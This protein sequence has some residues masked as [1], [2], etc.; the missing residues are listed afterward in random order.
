MAAF[1]LQ[2]HETRQLATPGNWLLCRKIPRSL[3]LDIEPLDVKNEKLFEGDQVAIGAAEWVNVT[4]PTDSVQQ[5]E[6]QSSKIRIYSN[7]GDSVSIAG[8]VA[9]SR[10][11]EGIQVEAEAFV[12]DGLQVGVITPTSWQSSPDQ[13]V[14]VGET[15]TVLN[16]NDQRS[17]AIVQVISD[18]PTLV[19]VGPEASANSG[20][21]ITGSW[22][23][24]GTLEI[25]TTGVVQVYNAGPEAARVSVTEVIK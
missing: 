2:P 23:I 12:R 18:E 13:A 22:D 8:E 25:E 3:L 4:N 15:V 10:I 17:K 9:V 6:L 1:A 11:S 14:V 5:V 21:M 7:G 20:V 24:P 19:R 16:A